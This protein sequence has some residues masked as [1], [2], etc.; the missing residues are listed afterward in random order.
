MERGHPAP[1][2]ADVTEFESRTKSLPRK[3][4]G[5]YRAKEVEEFLAQVFGTLRD[6]VAENDALRAGMSPQQ[7][8]GASRWR[9]LLTPFDIQAK[10]FQFARFQGGLSMREVDDLLDDLTAMLQDLL[11]ENESL[12]GRGSPSERQG[13]P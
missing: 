10:G 4:F 3:R 5:G 2:D 12:R 9:R 6:F 11:V 13:L 7:F 1:T 8:W